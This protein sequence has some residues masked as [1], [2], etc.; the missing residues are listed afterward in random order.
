MIKY[1]LNYLVFILTHCNNVLPPA[2]ILLVRNIF[3][4]GHTSSTF[5]AYTRKYI[6]TCTPTHNITCIFFTAAVLPVPV[7]NYWRNRWYFKLLSRLNQLAS[8]LPVGIKA[9]YRKPSN[10]RD[11]GKCCQWN[12]RSSRTYFYWTSSVEKKLHIEQHGKVNDHWT[13]LKG[14]SQ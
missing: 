12:Q 7:F 3:V 11:S 10:G 5:T 13:R 9:K 8:V 1:I 14:Y 6:Y 2:Q 4:G